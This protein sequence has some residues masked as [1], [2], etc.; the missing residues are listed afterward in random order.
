M[1]FSREGLE[2][3]RLPRDFSPRTGYGISQAL[4]NAW[5]Q[6]NRSPALV[7]PSAMAP[8]ERCVLLNP[9]HPSYSRCTWGN[10]IPIQLDSRL[11]AA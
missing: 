9:L 7:V 11:W 2:P 5:L 4:G 3:G 6:S 1:E 8:E 10:F